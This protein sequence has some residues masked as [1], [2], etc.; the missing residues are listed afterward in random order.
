MAVVEVRVITIVDGDDTYYH[1]D[2]NTA[3]KVTGTGRAAG[4]QTET[5][6]FIEDVDTKP[7]KY[8]IVDSV[9]YDGAKCK[10]WVTTDRQEQTRILGWGTTIPVRVESSEPEGE[11]VVLEFK[12]WDRSPQD[13][14]GFRRRRG[15]GH[16]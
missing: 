5:P 2:E 12:N 9:V 11:K 1:P 6:D 7:D 4:G 15:Y 13:L 14:Q 16:E 3:F 10:R 8:R